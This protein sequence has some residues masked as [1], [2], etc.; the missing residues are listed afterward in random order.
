MPVYHANVEYWQEFFRLYRSMPELWLTKS[1]C[2]RNRALKARSYQRLLDH[3]RT[4]EPSANIHTLKRKIN[5]FRTSYRRELRKMRR[6]K[7]NGTDEEQYVPTL[8][9]FKELDFLYDMELMDDTD[10]LGG[11]D[12][13]NEVEQEQLSSISI[14]PVLLPRPKRDHKMLELVDASDAIDLVQFTGDMEDD[15]IFAEPFSVEEDVLELD[16]DIEHVEE[17]SPSV[18][19]KSELKSENQTTID[20][21]QSPEPEAEP[22]TAETS[23]QSGKERRRRHSSADES[24]SDVLQQKKRRLN[25]H[26]AQKIDN[27][28][29]IIGKRMAVHFRNMRMDQRLFAERIISEVLIFGRMNR[30]SLD[31]RFLPNGSS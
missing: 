26:N 18:R 10:Y 29:D 27:E 6:C 3:M 1:E 21:I 24:V 8:W 28:C 19:V 17:S 15:D 2:Y 5:N 13:E 22:S 4:H 31:A 11:P 30:L 12:T 23:R 7:A 20:Y 16:G 14:S 25:L 9:Y